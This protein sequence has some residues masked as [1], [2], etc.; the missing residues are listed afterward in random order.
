MQPNSSQPMPRS[1]LFVVPR[2]HTN[3]AV[4][5][6][7]LRDAGC[8]VNVFAPMQGSLEDHSVVVPRIFPRT[9]SGKDVR[10]ALREVKPDLVFIR[11]CKPLSRIV[12]TYCR[13]RF[14][15]AYS[16]G[17]SSVNS[18]PSLGRRIA[19]FRDGQP[20][21]RMTPVR[22]VCSSAPEDRLR[23]TCPG[24]WRQ[25]RAATERRIRDPDHCAS[26]ASAS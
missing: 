7:I 16:Y 18:A 1:V 25:S 24:R 3:I 13:Y 10:A 21:R 17:L 12:G 22:D 14:V 23:P 11:S 20:L 9:T 8:Q 2:F 15:R 6:R 5:V 4:A 19:R 26:C